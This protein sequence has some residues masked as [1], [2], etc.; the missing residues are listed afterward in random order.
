MR[1]GALWPFLARM[2]LQVKVSKTSGDITVTH[3]FPEYEYPKD[4]RSQSIIRNAV[5]NLY[6]EMGVQGTGL[7]TTADPFAPNAGTTVIMHFANNGNEI[8]INGV[9]DSLATDYAFPHIVPLIHPEHKV[10]GRVLQMPS[11]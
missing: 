2:G 8:V 5:A 3:T 10:G 6:S 11:P 1:Q 9:A 4:P 7:V